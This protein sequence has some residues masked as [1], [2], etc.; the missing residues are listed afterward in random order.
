MLFVVC[1]TGIASDIY[2]PSIPAI[3]QEKNA[4]INLV[5]YAQEQKKRP[6][7]PERRVP[8]A[9]LPSSVLLKIAPLYE[10]QH[11]QLADKSSGIFLRVF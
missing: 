6:M 11:S 2:A 3:A 10:E 5:Q 4:P 9:F 1:V 8:W 7:A